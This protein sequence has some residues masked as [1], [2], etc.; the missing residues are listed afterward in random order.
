MKR[1]FIM[2]LA[3]TLLN[4]N[5]SCSDD[6]NSLNTIESSVTISDE[7]VNKVK[8][9]EL[10]APDINNVSYRSENLNAN[11]IAYASFLEWVSDEHV[12][13]V[14]SEKIRSSLD[15][16]F[17]SITEEVK[18]AQ[19]LTDEETSLI[20]KLNIE[21]QSIDFDKALNNFKEDLSFMNLDKSKNIF[22][23]NYIE[24]LKLSHYVY[25]ELF[26][27]SN[28]RMSAR[29]GSDCAWATGGLVLSFAGLA[30]GVGTALAAATF[31]YSSAAWGAAC[32]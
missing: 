12:E 32:L 5:Y 18:K 10:Y 14:L 3:L 22:F 13:V 19:N 29:G 25:P 11:D 15:S 30:S 26:E 8:K 24:S 20:L 6:E 1:I 27:V 16:D 4:L 23:E 31:I 17:E 2:F 28:V 9:I 21:L 7:I